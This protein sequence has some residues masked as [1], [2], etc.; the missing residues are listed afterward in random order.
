MRAS[1]R[2]PTSRPRSA[3]LAGRLDVFAL[4]DCD[5]G[6]P[7]RWNRCPKT[8]VEAP[9]AFGKQLDYRDPLLVGDIKYL[10]EPN[11]HL[12]LVTLAQAYALTGEAR[13]AEALRGQ[14]ESWF[15]ACPYR[16]GPNWSSSLEAGL[17]LVN[18]ALA[19]QLLGGVDAQV[20]RG[21]AGEAFRARWLASVYQHAEFVCGHLSLH[22]S[23]NNHLIGELAGVFTAALAWPHWGRALRWMEVARPMLER[24]ALLQNAPDGVN[25]EQATSYQQ[26]ELDLLLLPMLAACANAAPLSEAYRERIDAMLEYVA[27]IMDAGGNVPM[28]GDADDGYVVRLEP[29]AGFCRYKS[30]LATG[31]L[32]FGRGD[33]KAKAGRPRRQDALAAGRGGGGAATRRSTPRAPSC[34]C[35]ARFAEG[36]YYI[37]GCELRD[38]ARDPHRGRRGRL[39]LSRDR[40]PRPRRRARLHACGGRAGIPGRSR[41]LRVSHRGRLA[42][43]LP[44][45]VGAQHGAHRW[46]RPVAGRAATSCGCA[47]RAPRARS[48]IPRRP[49]M[50]SRART[51]ATSRSP[52][53]VTHRRRITLD[54]AARRIEHRGHARDGGRA[55]GRALPPLPRGCRGARGAGRPRDLARRRP[56]RDP[57][58]LSRRAGRRRCCEGALRPSAAGSRA[59]STTSSPR[60]RSPGGRGYGLR[61]ACAPAST[62]AMV[63][64]DQ[65]RRARGM[66]GVNS[67]P[68]LGP[69][70][71]QRREAAM[72]ISMMGLGYVGAVAAGCLAKEGHEVIGVDPQQAKV[73]LINA[74]KTPIIEKD[75]GEII[76]RAG[77]RGAP[78]S[79][80]PTCRPRCA[81]TDLSLVCVGH[82]QPRQRPHRP[83]VRPPR[84]RADRRGR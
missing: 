71:T 12:Q 3:S 35:G 30:L 18:W 41:H 14:L 65:P 47:T 11:R 54:K 52:I 73:D 67:D 50:S 33:F 81:R 31:A 38:A 36:G 70:T 80:P 17:R 64:E 78:A 53:P 7:P 26:F 75:I 74:G 83:Q 56:R 27:S 45:D 57:P 44:R 28:I 84:L 4:A 37:L 68:N 60:Q 32:L 76:A 51:T 72:K 13:Y 25:R 20:F 66:R 8:G 23:A 2:R 48:G 46:P 15:A 82:A 79:P 59:P 77:R 19:W 10:W 42:C 69:E 9:L 21:P 6:T 61:G 29:N 40:G 55:R 58:R 24:E 1:T 16:M 43:V 62:G 49:R 63:R 34:P 22:S 39:G 5:L